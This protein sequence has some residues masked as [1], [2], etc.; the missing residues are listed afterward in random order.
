MGVIIGGGS[1]EGRFLRQ[2]AAVIL[3]MAGLGLAALLVVIPRYHLQRQA[4]AMAREQAMK[5]NMRVLQVVLEQYLAEDGRGYPASLSNADPRREDP[6]LDFLS[7]SLKR[8]QN[9]FDKDEAP[10]AV[11]RRD[12]PF[13]KSFKRGQIIYV[14]LGVREGYADGYVIYG[15]GTKGPISMVMDRRPEPRRPSP[16]DREADRSD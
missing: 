13:W 3:G 4:V 16:E 7:S 11:S 10:V 2:W 5:G 6:M 15:L 14:P 8:L 1:G 12:P 9:P